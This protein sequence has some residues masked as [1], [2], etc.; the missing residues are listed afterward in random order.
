MIN[1]AG[2]SG[3]EIP[4]KIRNGILSGEIPITDATNQMNRWIQFQTALT[5]AGL[6]GAD[7]PKKMRNGI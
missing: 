1:D 3:A 5:T 2:L 7:I 6:S 4:N